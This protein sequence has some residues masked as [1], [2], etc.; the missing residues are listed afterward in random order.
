M[1]YIFDPYTASKLHSS[2]D[3]REARRKYRMNTFQGKY[4]A[5]HP[6]DCATNNSNILRET[7]FVSLYK[8]LN[9]IYFFQFCAIE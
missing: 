7:K 9:I 3:M 1:F 6:T 4:N 5:L 2:N 8:I